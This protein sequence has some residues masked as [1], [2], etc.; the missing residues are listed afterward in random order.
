MQQAMKKKKVRT[1]ADDMLD[2]LRTAKWD[3]GWIRV[4]NYGAVMLPTM[5]WYL[6]IDG[7]PKR[8]QGMR[9]VDSG[10]RAAE[11]ALRKRIK[12]D[13]KNVPSEA[14]SAAA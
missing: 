5:R 14:V 12:A 3:H 1:K 10:K 7:M 4:E 9:S 2:V 6:T 13:F 11:K 8:A